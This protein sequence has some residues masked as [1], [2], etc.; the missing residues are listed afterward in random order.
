M[1][2]SLASK[3]RAANSSLFVDGKLETIADFFSKDYV[4]HI[5]GQSIPGGHT[6]IRRILGEIQR[7]F[8]ALRVDVEILVEAG[9]RIAWQRTLRGVQ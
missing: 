7:A 3:I 5:T 4:I 1:S 6:A 8:P 2:H 9:D